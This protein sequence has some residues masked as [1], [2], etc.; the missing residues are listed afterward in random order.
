MKYIFLIILLCNFLSTSTGYSH[1]LTTDR[2]CWK[3]MGEAQSLNLNM[4]SF[5]ASMT[6]K[7]PQG[8]ARYYQRAMQS[9]QLLMKTIQ[10]LPQNCDAQL[11]RNLMMS[12]QQFF[13]YFSISPFAANM[14]QLI[15]NVYR[16]QV[17]ILNQ[18]FPRE[19]KNI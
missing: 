17:A 18:L 15:H 7:Q 11:P 8:S 4:S 1:A 5:F 12:V 16:D 10:E 2:A 9:L 6:K 3:P 14:P 13:H 19:Q